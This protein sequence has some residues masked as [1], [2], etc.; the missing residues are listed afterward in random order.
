MPC[1]ESVSSCFFGRV[2]DE[3]ELGGLLRS[4]L[5]FGF[6]EEPSCVVDVVQS[7]AEREGSHHSQQHLSEYSPHRSLVVAPQDP[8][9]RRQ[10]NGGC[11]FS[12]KRWEQGPP[13]YGEMHEK[14]SDEDTEISTDSQD[15]DP[16]GD[17][18]C[19]LR[20][21]DGKHDQ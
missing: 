15:R 3:V 6:H 10:L 16:S 18:N 4:S 19:E 9:N 2:P 12:Q 1:R 17:L 11:G 21:V 5:I 13:A 7:R 20:V 8:Q 14:H